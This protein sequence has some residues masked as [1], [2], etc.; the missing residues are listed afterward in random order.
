MAE[1]K[2]WMTM[3]R[4]WVGYYSPSPYLKFE[5]IPVPIPIPVWMATFVPVSIPYGYPYPYP[6]STFLLKIIRSIIK[7]YIILIQLK[8]F[9]RF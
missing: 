4:V 2:L 7:Y 6:L 1:K 9:Q 8:K 5:K 3:G